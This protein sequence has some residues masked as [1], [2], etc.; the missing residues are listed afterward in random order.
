MEFRGVFII[1]TRR[2]FKYLGLMG[3]ITKLKAKLFSVEGL[4]IRPEASAAFRRRVTW[5]PPAD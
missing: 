1:D 2:F 4:S 3:Y 5:Q